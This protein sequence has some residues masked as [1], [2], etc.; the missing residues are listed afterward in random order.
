VKQ[1]HQLRA[2]VSRVKG[3]DVDRCRGGT[4][5]NGRIRPIGGDEYYARDSLARDILEVVHYCL[6][7]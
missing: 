3:G 7:I 1:S 6:K 2:V 5:E 4:Y